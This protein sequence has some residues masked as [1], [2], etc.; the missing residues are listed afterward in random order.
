MAPRLFA[1]LGAVV[2]FIK[3]IPKSSF[4]KNARGGLSEQAE[5]IVERK[6]KRVRSGKTP[7]PRP[8]PKRGVDPATGRRQTFVDFV[9]KIQRSSFPQNAASD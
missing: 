3:K 7:S 9:E 8:G 6:L 4:W 5:T 1:R 2:D